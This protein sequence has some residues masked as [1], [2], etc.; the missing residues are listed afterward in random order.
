MGGTHADNDEPERVIEGIRMS[1]GTVRDA[2][3]PHGATEK[4]AY[5]EEWSQSGTIRKE[6]GR[7][8]NESCQ[9]HCRLR[10][11]ISKRDEVRR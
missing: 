10:K 2:G 5:S 1:V 11:P 8:T 7:R 9:T 4:R 3:G 6:V